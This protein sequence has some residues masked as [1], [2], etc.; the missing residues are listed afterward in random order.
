[1]AAAVFCIAAMPAEATA[2]PGVGK[3][4]D[5][6]AA[7]LAEYRA[8]S[9]LLATDPAHTLTVTVRED[10][11]VQTVLPAHFVRAGL[12]VEQLAARDLGVLR[13]QLASADLLRFD[14]ASLRQKRA[15]LSAMSTPQHVR[16]FDEDIV[17]IE[18]HPALAPDRLKGT[19]RI[20]TSSLRAD[21][22]AL[23]DERALVSLGAAQ[24]M[25]EEL[26]ERHYAAE[27]AR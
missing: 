14:A 10:G 11:C 18:L 2:G 27:A 20:R 19:K 24:R 15:T 23:P 5:S 1:M 6:A 17:E 3:C 8:A 25:F 7:I 9:P 12:H 21:L 26:A 4:A 16:V 13:H 22:L